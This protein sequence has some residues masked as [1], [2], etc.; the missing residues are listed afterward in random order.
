[1][2][3][4]QHNIFAEHY[5]SAKL[6]FKTAEFKN[7]GY[8]YNL[9]ASNLFCA[10]C[11]EAYLNHLGAIEI[12]DWEQWDLENK[13]NIK[14]KLLKISNK[15][16]FKID[17]RNKPYSI[18]T[19]LFEYRTLVVHGKTKI[20]TKKIKTPPN[21]SKACMLNFASDMEKFCTFDKTKINLN[22]IHKII[23]TLNKKSNFSLSTN[24]LWSIGNGSYQIKY[25]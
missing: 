5:K 7:D 20:V 9:V 17:Y 15:L 1:M 22:S 24:R 25:P 11:F 16:N 12:N 18:I 14:A 2:D 8:Y 13:P 3:Y 23:E 6:F 4:F 21:N 19:P 10:L